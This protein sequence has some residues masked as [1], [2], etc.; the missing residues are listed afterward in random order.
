MRPRKPTETDLVRECIRI[1]HTLGC[2]AWRCNV[3]AFVGEYRG[4]RRVVR[5]GIKGMADILGILPGG[6]FLAVECKLGKN[7]LTTE[8][9]EFHLAIDRQ[10]GVVM[11]ARDVETFAATLRN[12]IAREKEPK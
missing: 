4:R 8:Q 1:A 3:G 9:T 7:K 5:F 11:V 6:R 12:V 2:L 10:G